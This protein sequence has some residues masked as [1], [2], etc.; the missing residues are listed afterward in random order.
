[1]AKILLVLGT[2]FNFI[3]FFLVTPTLLGEK[4]L[5]NLKILFK[6]YSVKG[7]SF[8]ER[9]RSWKKLKAGEQDILTRS[10]RLFFLFEFIFG[11][12]PFFVLMFCSIW[13]LCEFS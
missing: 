5:L 9:Y 1:M 2:V 6:T 13:F 10:Q 4:L 11:A 7:K 8:F 12:I 3:S